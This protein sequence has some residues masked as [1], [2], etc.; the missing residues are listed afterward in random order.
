MYNYMA[1][2]ASLFCIGSID[3]IENGMAHVIFTTDGP[4]S[5]EAD[6]P[7]QLFPCEISEGDLFY[8]QIIDGVTELRCGEPQI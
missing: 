7:V 3:M 4:E 5:Y 1:I 2:L 8:A 6:I